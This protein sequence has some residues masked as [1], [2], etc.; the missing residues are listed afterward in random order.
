MAL[1][2]PDSDFL[3]WLDNY[4][5]DL[6]ELMGDNIT[7]QDAI[8]L[9]HDICNDLHRGKSAEAETG[10]IYRGMPKIS[11]KLAGNLVSAAQQT[12]CRDTLT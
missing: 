2:D 4:G 9:G 8:E 1:A 3:S 11:D 7:R 6:S 5:I 12:I 10:E